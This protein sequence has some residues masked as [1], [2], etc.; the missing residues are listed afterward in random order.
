MVCVCIVFQLRMLMSGR[1]VIF[2]HVQIT[3]PMRPV[4]S[5]K[6]LMHCSQATARDHHLGMYK[7]FLTV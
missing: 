6:Q 7:D 2:C 4:D 3:K 5:V 1:S